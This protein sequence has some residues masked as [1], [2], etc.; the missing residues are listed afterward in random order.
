[1][2]LLLEVV[3]GHC[4]IWLLLQK[5]EKDQVRLQWINDH[6]WTL[7]KFA[8]L[9]FIGTSQC[10]P[11]QGLLGGLNVQI[12]L[13]CL[14]TNF[15]ITLGSIRIASSG[16][17]YAP[18]KLVPLSDLICLIFPRRAIKWRKDKIKESLVRSP[19]ISE[20]MA[21]VI[22]RVNITPYCLTSA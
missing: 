9:I 22:M 14:W 2:I 20:C 8:L 7:L 19:T 21:R 10:P 6:E 13:T 1:M 11:I 18:S 4:L 3:M 17:F 5:K 12:K 15:D 16:S